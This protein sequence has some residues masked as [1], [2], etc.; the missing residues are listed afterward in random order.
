MS[1]SAEQQWKSYIDDIISQYGPER[2]NWEK[3]YDINTE[4]IFWYNSNTD[5]TIPS[6]S[7]HAPNSSIA[8]CESCDNVFDPEDPSDK[9]YF[10]EHP[11]SEINFRKYR[12]RLTNL[13]TLDYNVDSDENNHD[14]LSQLRI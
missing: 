14:N 12:G 8:I 5:E 2:T 10:C 9:C 11:R 13:S 7:C 4:S 1:Q 6:F 3:L